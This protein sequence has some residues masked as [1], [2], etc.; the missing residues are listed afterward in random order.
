MRSDFLPFKLNSMSF[1]SSFCSIL[2]K[3]LSRGVVSLSSFAGERGLAPK[4]YIS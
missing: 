4:F 3:L 2:G 1:S